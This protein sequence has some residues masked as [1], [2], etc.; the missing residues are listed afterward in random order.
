MS[1]EQEHTPPPVQPTDSMQSRV[2]GYIAYWFHDTHPLH[3]FLDV[4]VLAL[5]GVF[6]ITLWGVYT[7]QETI[8]GMVSQ[9]MRTSAVIDMAAAEEG[10]Q[11]AWAESQLEGAVALEL[12]EIDL[13]SNTRRLLKISCTDPAHEQRIKQHIHRPFVANATN[14]EVNNILGDLLSGDPAIGPRSS[15]LGD[16][17]ALWVPLPDKP[18][19]T[20]TGMLIISFPKDIDRDSLRV[21]RGN[22]LNFTASLT[23]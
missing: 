12:W 14:P 1:D 10:W 4:L 17:T 6:G 9:A 19:Q 20:L 3:K 7:Q 23:E 2:V 21:A 8:L 11:T 15:S 5:A 13:Q 18:A 16:L 22:L